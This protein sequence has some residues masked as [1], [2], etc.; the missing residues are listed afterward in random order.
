MNKRGLELAISTLVIII[1]AIIVLV[2]LVLFF[3]GG[4]NTFKDYLTQTAP[5]ETQ[6]VIAACESACNSGLDY[7]FC[8]RQRS[9]D[10]YE[11]ITCQSEILNVQC[12]N[13]QC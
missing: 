1:I 5:S 7:D 6:A 9:V 8:Q 4:W 12:N 10:G 3:T 13:I 2:S 11:N